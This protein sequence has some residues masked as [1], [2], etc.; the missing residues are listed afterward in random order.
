MF[1]VEMLPAGRGDCIWIEYGEPPDTHVVLIDG[2][3][4]AT[5]DRIQQ[6]IAKRRAA[7][8]MAGADIELLVVTHIDNDHIQGIIELLKSSDPL[9]SVGDIWFNGRLQLDN[10]AL[11]EL[12]QSEFLDVGAT[13]ESL[14]WSCEK[15]KE[16]PPAATGMDGFLGVP[17]GDELSL[18]LSQREIPWNRHAPF[19]NAAV[20]VVDQVALPVVMLEDGLMLTVLGPTL[21]RLQLLRAAWDKSRHGDEDKASESVSPFLARTDQWPPLWDDRVA[22]DRSMTNGS[23]ILLLVEFNGVQILL[24]GDAHASD[25]AAAID[26]VRVERTLAAP[27]PLAAFKLSH[28]GS[29]ANLSREVLE[30]IDC[31]RFLISTDG[32]VHR[33][34]D[35]LALLRVLRYSKAPTE[36]LFNYLSPTTSRWGDSLDDIKRLGYPPYVA[37]FPSDAGEGIVLD[38]IANRSKGGQA[39]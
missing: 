35:Q 18:L 37:H 16:K 26:R 30:K 23:S 28:H 1:R 6:R 36:L 39:L 33:H 22:C 24:A 12:S 8:S 7:G 17:E 29:A 15:K 13:A 25:I 21:S 4:K 3:V 14:G 2:G 38:L 9:V 10:L 5:A 20:G 19:R 27:L 34:P 32:S 11:P 31:R